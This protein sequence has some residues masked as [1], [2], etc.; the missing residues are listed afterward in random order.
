MRNVMDYHFLEDPTH[1]ET[2]AK[3]GIGSVG[4]M[5]PIYLLTSMTVDGEREL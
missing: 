4:K 1:P 2:P 5:T 3:N